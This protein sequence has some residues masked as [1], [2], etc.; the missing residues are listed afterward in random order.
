MR[1]GS[2]LPFFWFS[3]P[4]Y[5]VDMKV[6]KWGAGVLA[7]VT[8]VVLLVWWAIL[9]PALDVPGGREHIISGVTVINPGIERLVNQSII[10]R[11]GRI[12]E[13][14]ARIDSDPA[15]VCEGCFALPGL[16]DAHVH[17]PPSFIVG[18]QRLFALMY[19]RYG[20]TSVRDVGQSD[21]SVVDFAASLND[22]QIVG[23]YMYRCGPVLEGSPPGWPVARVVDTAEAARNAVM[24]FADRGVDCIKVYNE[25]NEES[26]RA[27]RAAAAERNLPLIGHVPHSVK[28]G[29]VEN[30]E[31]QHFTGI[32]YL[33]S[34]RPPMGWDY[35]DEDIEAMSDADIAALGEIFIANRLSITPTLANHTLRLTDSDIERFPP[36]AGAAH[37]PAFWTDSWKLVAGHPQGEEAVMRRIATQPR[38]D[39]IVAELHKAGVD[40]LAGTD[41]LMPWVVPGESLHLELARLEKALGSPEAALKAATVT[42]GAHIAPGQI[43][44]LRPGAR[45]DILVLRDDPT[46]SLSALSG[47]TVVIANGRRYDRETVD[48]WLARYDAHFHGV[49]YNT[50]VSGLVSRLAKRFSHRHAED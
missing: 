29:I 2:G 23:P 36:T 25:V 12:E 44:T 28:L 22:G 46:V 18:N 30:F 26:F 37:L 34:A 16:I 49:L 45:A 39:A 9:P 33:A 15:P 47:W 32:P 11:D 27:I 6:V 10:I 31:I 42:S 35:R 40:V 20:V 17:T 8:C 7:A 14:R 50:V 5:E 24:E 19:L 13:I 43:G 3:T 4:I 1:E 41:T 48:G 21:A 38:Y